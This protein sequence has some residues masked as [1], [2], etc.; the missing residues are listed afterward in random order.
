MRRAIYYVAI[1][2]RDVSTDLDPILISLRIQL[3]AKSKADGC[4]IELDDT[5][6]QIALP[7]TGA[8]VEAGIA[9]EDGGPPVQFEGSIKSVQHTLS[10]GGGS[11]LTLSARSAEM[12]GKLKERRHAHHDKGKLSDVAQKFGK[13]AGVTVKVDKAL[14]E[15]ERPYWFQAGEAFPTWGQ[16]IAR[17]IG[18]TFKV[19]GNTALFVPRN[20]GSSASGQALQEIAVRR[21]VNLITS[22]LSPCNNDPDFARVT[23]RYYD[24][25]KARWEREEVEVGSGVAGVTSERATR[26]VA[27]DQ[28]QAKARAKSNAADAERERGG[29]TVQIDGEPAAMPEAPCTVEGVRPG[30]DGPYRIDAVAHEYSR[31]SGFLTTLTLKQPRKGSGAGASPGVDGRGSAPA[32]AGVTGGSASP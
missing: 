32:P 29:G 13:E 31:R 28:A 21:G 6:A 20:G 10:R 2:G 12:Y 22:S 1:D 7:R 5:D 23:V 30:I 3:S 24:R 16:R 11:I 14:G 4:E 15:I 17:E 8:Q 18:A 26:W 25:K 27:P 19:I 9:W